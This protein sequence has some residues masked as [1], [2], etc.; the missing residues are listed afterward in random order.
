L[1][2][3]PWSFPYGAREALAYTSSDVIQLGVMLLETP[4]PLV[5]VGA[6]F[7]TLVARQAAGVGVVAAWALVPV[8]AHALYWFHAPRMLS[9]AAPA[10]IL[11]AVLAVAHARERAGPA[12]R[13]GIWSGVVA[14]AL[15]A[16]IGFLPSRVLMQAWPEETLSRITLSD[17]DADGMLVFVHAGWEERLASTLQATG[18]RNDSIQSVVR[19]NDF[20]ELQAYATARL[21]GVTGAALPPIDLEQT[22]APVG[23]LVALRQPGGSVV[24]R[25]EGA[26]WSEA[27]VIE[28]YADRYGAV[29]LAPLLWQGDL[30]G[31]ER[32]EPMFVRDLGAERN[33]AVRSHY[34]NRDVGMWM[35]P[36]S[37]RPVL[38]PYDVAMAT[39]WTLPPES[40]PPPP[41]PE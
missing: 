36:P 23:G 4:L 30:P 19:R 3:D 2:T 7:L 15:I 40:P 13:V 17:A 20:C 18:M 6:A 32:G 39:L 16:G 34:P 26:Q 41:G 14:T 5:L 1:H 11:L 10:W 35:Y 28:M 8:F 12:L 9:E 25:G 33:D 38:M 24:W 27:C 37:G 22:G 31:L 29:A 21:A